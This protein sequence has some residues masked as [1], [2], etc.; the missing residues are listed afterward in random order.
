MVLFH[1]TRAIQGVH[2]RQVV[3]TDGRTET[4]VDELGE[5]RPGQ[6]VVVA[7]EG[8]IPL[9]GHPLQG[10]SGVPDC[11][12]SW[13]AYPE[14]MSRT[15]LTKGGDPTHHC[16][17]ESWVGVGDDRRRRGARGGGGSCRRRCWRGA[18]RWKKTNAQGRGPCRLPCVPTG[19]RERLAAR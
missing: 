17:W 10:Q 16:S 9:D 6:D 14:S 13:C 18:T 5:A 19:H 15:Y 8:V 7:F 2:F 12:R 4:H 3:G 1:R 11:L